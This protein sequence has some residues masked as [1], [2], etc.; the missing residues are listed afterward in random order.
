VTRRRRT[1]GFTLLEVMIA[2]AILGAALIV[3]LRIS[4][5]DVR[6][7]YRA[8]LLTI[9]TQLARSKMNDIEEELAKNGFTDTG[10]NEQGDF[11]DEGQKKFLWEATI[12]KVVLPTTDQ[13]SSD[14]GKDAKDGKSPSSAA[15][16]PGLPGVAGFADSM[17]GNKAVSEMM[18]TSS[19]SAT[20]G[21]GASMVQMYFPLIS[22]ILENAIRKVTLTVKWRVGTTS[23]P[24]PIS[25]RNR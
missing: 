20:G 6:A 9:A 13:L 4:S 21:L 22:P 15:A 18:G 25:N 2:L 16:A 3:L 1:W 14:L 24:P 12:E 10:E 17:L 5:Q 19:G 11:T 7:S 23:A 8:K